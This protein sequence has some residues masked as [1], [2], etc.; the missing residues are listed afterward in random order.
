MADREA[1]I[2]TIILIDARLDDTAKNKVRTDIC[3]QLNDGVNV[4][5]KDKSIKKII[6]INKNNGQVIVEL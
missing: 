4:L 5:V 2:L 3:N 6:L 1:D